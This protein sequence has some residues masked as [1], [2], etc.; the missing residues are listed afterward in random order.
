M[1]FQ[2][3]FL[4]IGIYIPFIVLLLAS[5]SSKELTVAFRDID[6]TFSFSSTTRLTI[7]LK[8]PHPKHL[9][10]YSPEEYVYYFMNSKREFDEIIFKDKLVI[11]PLNFK[12]IRY[13]EHSGEP[14]EELVFTTPGEYLL[15][16]ADNTE[17]EPDNTFFTERS[18]RFK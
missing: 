2:R 17:T 7:V 15:Y 9:L 4:L 5:C 13:D 1:T 16:F 10:I 18:I 6:S 14:I 8:E 12:G 11:D 3:A